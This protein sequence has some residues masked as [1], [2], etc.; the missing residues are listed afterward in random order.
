MDM[1]CLGMGGGRDTSPAPCIGRS[2]TENQ[3]FLENT[4]DKYTYNLNMHFFIFNPTSFVKPLKETVYS[5][6]EFQMRL[7]CRPPP[8]FFCSYAPARPFPQLII[9]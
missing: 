9:A 6:V 2:D 4:T 8:I 1:I 5:L 3:K 7:G